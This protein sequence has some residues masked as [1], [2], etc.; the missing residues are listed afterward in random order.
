LGRWS[1]GYVISGSFW[2]GVI[3]YVYDGYLV[4]DAVEYFADARAIFETR[5]DEGDSR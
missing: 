4:S 1:T 3:D 5:Y 2:A